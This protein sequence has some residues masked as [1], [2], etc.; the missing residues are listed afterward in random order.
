MIVWY[1]GSHKNDLLSL[2]LSFSIKKKY[3]YLSKTFWIHN[4]LCIAKEVYVK[5]LILNLIPNIIYVVEE[6]EL[7]IYWRETGLDL[8]HPAG[9]MTWS[10]FI[11][12]WLLAR[13]NNRSWRWWW[14]GHR[15]HAS[16]AG[17]GL[18]AVATPKCNWLTYCNTTSRSNG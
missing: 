4:I 3:F 15:T 6:E 8:Q 13:V 9:C 12:R 14:L 1:R 11:T 10:A 2:I 16:C 7:N 17:G 5:Y 18:T